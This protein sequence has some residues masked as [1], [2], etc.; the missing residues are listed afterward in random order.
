[1]NKKPQDNWESVFEQLPL[2]TAPSTEHHA[3]LKE[4]VLKT[5]DEGGKETVDLTS[6]RPAVE[7]RSQESGLKTTGRLLMT[8][9]AP[10][11][12][13]AAVIIGL[14]AWLTQGTSAAFAF[15]DLVENVLT[16]RTA[17]YDG[18]F[19]L[20]EKAQSTE[21]NFY[22]APGKSRSETEDRVMVQNSGRVVILAK[23]AKT[24]TV[25]GHESMDGA[26]GMNIFE[27]F[28][29]A[30]Q[31]PDSDPFEVRE[32]GTR[33]VG[34]R[35]EVGFEVDVAIGVGKNAT[36]VVWA[37]PSTKFPVEIEVPVPEGEGKFIYKNYE[38]DI[39][40]DEELFSTEV[41]EGYEIQELNFDLGGDETADA[42]DPEDILA[43]MTEGTFIAGLKNFVEMTGK[44][45][46]GV[47]PISLSQDMT[48]YMQDNKISNDKLQETMQELM[49]PVL[50]F[51]A[52]LTASPESNA[53][54]DAK[55]AKVGD[56]TKPIFWYKPNGKDD[57]RV[58]YA[59]YSVKES[60]KAPVK[61]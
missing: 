6:A 56:G 46:T 1:M 31:S 36:F 54:Y 4:R 48:K 44:L 53:D 39:E 5:F 3:E 38:F 24:A 35:T 51:P 40:L 28:R 19:M 57:Y 29:D 8:Y 13:A 15:E 27:M 60:A 58:I 7:S 49:M 33:T 37:D 52:T 9:K 17:R 23:A 47:D 22:M 43:G 45:P 26:G 55:D 21:K 30:L 2:D 41:P 20:D 25:M 12:T 34:D 14:F 50:Q 16:C 11:W 10:Y 18:V 32:L 59:D 42:S 61:K